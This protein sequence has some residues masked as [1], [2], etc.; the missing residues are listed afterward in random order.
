MR[1]VLAAVATFTISISVASACTDV[2][3]LALPPTGNAPGAVTGVV[4]TA[5]IGSAVVS[6]T[7]LSVTA[8][9]A[10]YQVLTATT[11]WASWSPT[12]P[13]AIAPTASCCSFAFSD[14][15]NDVRRWFAVRAISTEGVLGE[16][17]DRV[18]A[19]PPGWQ[20]PI[21]VGTGSFDE[22]F[23]IRFASDAIYV[24]GITSGTL[25]G[26]TSAGGSDAFLAKFDLAGRLMW[27]RQFGTSATDS[28]RALAV[29]SAGMLYVAGVTG[30]TLQGT[31]AGG[32]D[33]FL[34]KY[35]PAGERI[36]IQQLGGTDTDWG[37]GVATDP[38]G[39]SY[40][41]GET[42]SNLDGNTI[43]GVDDAFV[44]KYNAAGSRQWT[45]TFGT[46]GSD[47]AYAAAV[48]ASGSV[49][50]TGMTAGGLEGNSSAGGLDLFVAKV[51]SSGAKLWTRQIGTAASDAGN[52]ISADEA[53]NVTV[54]GSSSGNFD[55]HTNASASTTD[56]ILVRYSSAGAKSW[57]DQFGGDSNDACHAIETEATVTI[58][59]GH[60]ISPT[61]DGERNLGSYD[62]FLAR[63]EDDVRA[64]TRR[65]GTSGDEAVGG[66]ALGHSSTSYV[67][68]RSNGAVGSP[69]GGHD[70][71][72]FKADRTGAQP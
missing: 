57:S 4:A 40:L 67:A 45:R 62:A 38:Q 26:Q 53:D 12:L 52:A 70:V 5:G 44:A 60:F 43:V 6:W 11:N 29:G 69:S 72:I 25:S 22:A 24:A 19:L 48:D 58:V 35:S 7:A 49:Y 64:W 9:V 2:V 17:S 21:Q 63:Y 34:A 61:L 37:R 33:A 18:S 32:D 51:S 20:G 30:G 15:E 54:C 59:G 46:S 31:S 41:V 1:P 28:I 36:W 66:V 27:I 56:V 50:L 42:R 8:D 14:L 23:A 68:G 71:V 55:G 47:A 16:E 13:G 3:H 10:T 65:F 39:N